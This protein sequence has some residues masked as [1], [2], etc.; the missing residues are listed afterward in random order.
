MREEVFALGERVLVLQAGRLLAHGSPYEVLEK[1]RHEAIAEFAGIENRFDGTVVAL[2]EAQGTLTC[3]LTE[4]E[5]GRMV[6]L[7]IPL[8][9]RHPGMPVRVAIRAGDIMLATMPPQGISA[10]NVLPGRLISLGR[11]DTTVIAQ[12]DCGVRFEVHLTPA[13]EKALELR[14]GREVWLVI[15][16]H[17]CHILRS[18]S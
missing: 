14:P 12:V 8:A 6:E 17:S 1:P 15:K 9:H 4:A 18:G 16:T 2:H 3:R 10:R 5:E 11:M 7:E 13:A